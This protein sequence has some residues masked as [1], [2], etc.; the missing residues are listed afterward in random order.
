MSSR[1]ADAA[2]LYAHYIGKT[3]WPV[4]LTVSYPQQNWSPWAVTGAGAILVG[5]TGVALWRARREPYLVVG[6]L[7]YLGTLVPVSGLV[8]AGSQPMADHYTYLQL[9]GLFIMV[10]WSIPDNAV[11]PHA[12][13][14]I[15]TVVAV[16]MLV[17]S[18]TLSWSQ[19]QY[20]RNSETLFRHA[21]EVTP[22]NYL[23]HNN[24][25]IALAT[26]ES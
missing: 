7:W 19:I 26:R 9:L 16:L 4:G 8:Q 15:V 14:V 5:I 24:L 1:V 13:K 6:W 23:A 17:A 2:V 18:A 21:L 22:D 11:N 12:G 10:A 3:F 20:W 25:G